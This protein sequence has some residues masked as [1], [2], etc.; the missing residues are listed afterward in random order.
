MKAP[1]ILNLIPLV[2]SVKSL[3]KNQGARSGPYGTAPMITPQSLNPINAP[4]SY[5]GVTVRYMP[6]NH[7]IQSLV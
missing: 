3:R 4:D 7:V 2:F 5:T 6:S 1:L